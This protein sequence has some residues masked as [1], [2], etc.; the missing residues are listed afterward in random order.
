LRSTLPVCAL[1][2]ALGLLTAPAANAQGKVTVADTQPVW[3]SPSN[4]AGADPNADQVVFSVWLGWSRNGE[5]D[6]TL[7]DL[8]DPA[9]P[10]YHQWLTPDQFHARFSPRASD[11]ATVR[12]WLSSDGFS[13]VDVPANRLFVAAEGSVAQVEHA[14][15][16][17]EKMYRVDGSVLREPNHDPVV[18]AAVAP[19]VSAITGLDGAMTLAHPN[20]DTPPPPPAGTSVGP[21]SSYWGQRTSSDFT[22][23]YGA[24]PLP[25]LIC[26]YQPAQ[27]DS[28]Y[29]IDR[30]HAAGLDG[31]GQTIA[32]TGAFF[33]PTIRQ[34][35]EHFSRRFHLDHGHGFLFH[36]HGSAGFDYRE[37]VAPGTQRFP[38]DPAETQSW[39]IEQ[40][41]DVEWAHAV[42][43]GARI[44]Y[45]GAAN[46]A[47]GL[48]QAVN[49]VVDH[50]LANI[51]SNSCGLPESLAPR[52]EILAMNAVFQQ[53]A[54]EGIGV[55]FAS[56][57]DG[58]N[59][60]AA[61]KVSAGFPD[62]SP[63]VTS[64]GGTSL[65]IDRRGG[66]QWESGWGTTTTDWNGKKWSPKAPGDFMYGSGGG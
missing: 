19:L 11:V 49:E 26:G 15:G 2:A 57:D 46:D 53:A 3:A 63:W 45:V 14:F 64:V 13:I 60:A 52:G 23:P 65:A 66:Y 58:D 17:N 54:A 55:Y 42:A 16:V 37:L 24:G 6:R 56:G 27:I 47:G 61:G 10:A 36:H 21:C 28:A 30:L 32:I 5:L 22:N 9:S 18:P 12:S 51:V 34:D 38:K 1:C 33:S 59:R 43:P 20:V 40:A 25:W 44:V 35:V 48:D 41:L 31:R 62:S 8:Y 7:T 4:L 39:Y 29:G 50:H